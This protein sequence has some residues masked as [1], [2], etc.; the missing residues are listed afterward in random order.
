M[1]QVLAT[2][3]GDELNQIPDEIATK[4]CAAVKKNQREPY[5]D[6]MRAVLDANEPDY[7]N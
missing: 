6:A 1:Y 2:G 4:M 7:A 3:D 5:F